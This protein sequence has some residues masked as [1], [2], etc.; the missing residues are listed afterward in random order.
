MDEEIIRK[1]VRGVLSG[2]HNTPSA[3]EIRIEASGRHVHLTQEALESLFGAD[4]KLE[5]SAELSQPGEYLSDKRVK[6]ITPK[7]QLAEVAVLAPVRKTV[8]VELSATDCRTLGINAPVNLSGDLTGAAD[9]AIMGSHGLINAVGSTIIAKAHIHLTRAEAATYG[10]SDAEHVRVR[11]ESLRPLT[12]D[13]VVV[14]VNDRFAAAVHIDYDEANACGLDKN[15]RAYI[16]GGQPVFVGGE[17]PMPP[18]PP[19]S[20]SEKLVTEK[21]AKILVSGNEN[22]LLRLNK[23]TI[24]TPAARDVFTAARMKL[25]YI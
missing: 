20:W 1:I 18:T 23:G 17:T 6:I 13:D 4:A 9:V 12:F 14:R 25:E 16:L 24:V 8:Q 15:T 11:V 5:V 7:G 10:V 2:K 21:T 22:G 3:R 19:L